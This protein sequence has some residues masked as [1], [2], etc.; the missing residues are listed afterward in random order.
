MSNPFKAIADWCGR[1]KKETWFKPV[2]VIIVLTAIAFGVDRWRKYEDAK[3]QH[4][5]S[6]TE[7]AEESLLEEI[8]DDSKLHLAVF[9]SL[10]A[11]LFA[12]QHSKT[13]L[14]QTGG[15]EEK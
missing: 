8:W 11:A 2:I 9:L 12:V 15:K 5:Q 1:N 4:Q 14:K 7:Q 6:Q 3:E 13:R 10:S